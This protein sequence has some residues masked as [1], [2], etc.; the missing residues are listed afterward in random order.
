MSTATAADYDTLFGCQCP[1]VPLVHLS[2]SI[3]TSADTHPLLAVSAGAVITAGLIAFGGLL[4]FL[5]KGS[6]ASLIAGGESR[7]SNLRW[8]KPSYLRRP[9]R[10]S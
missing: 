9:A 3:P 7:L 10:P 6:V 1:P 8:P 4:G 5:R 2:P